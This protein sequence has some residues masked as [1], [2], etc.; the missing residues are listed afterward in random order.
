MIVGL[1]GGIGSGKTAAMR[2]FEG[3]GIGCVDADVVAREVVEPGTPALQ[4]LA[5]RFGREI[6]TADGRLDRASLRQRIFSSEEDK[7]WLEGLL[8]PLIREEM[9]RQLQSISSPYR[10]LVAPLLFE[11]DLDRQ[12][13]TSVLIDVP[14]DIQIERVVD[15]DGVDREQAAAIIRQQ[16][17]RTEKLKRADHIVSNTGS[18]K[19]L[20]KQLL[21][22]HKEFMAQS[23]ATK[24]SKGKSD[25][26]S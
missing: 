21:A 18:L 1:T 3:F 8:H 4:A 23:A 12:C 22:L 6:L 15:R 7:R 9:Q 11:N 16:M 14:E 19:D 26:D 13:D 10:V 5:E 2:I 24:A 20:E 17:S 25:D